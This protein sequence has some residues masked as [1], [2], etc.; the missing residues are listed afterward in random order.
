M[1]SI[2]LGQNRMTM[3]TAKRLDKVAEYYFSR[4]LREI[5][6]LVD[7]GADVINMGIGN[8]D[9]PPP[10]EVID[11]LSNSALNENN[12]GY[13]PYRGTSMFRKEIARWYENTYSVTLDPE[14]E[15]LPLLGSKEGIFYVSMAFLNPGDRV[16][17]PDPGYAPYAAAARLAGATP[18]NYD[19]SEEKGWLPDLDEL[20]K[21]DLGGVKL[22][23]INYPNMPTGATPPRELFEKLVSLA[24]D[25]GLLICHDNPY[26]LILNSESPLSIFQTKGAKECSLELNSL[27]KS[28]RMAGWRVGMICGNSRIIDAVTRVKSNVDSGMFYPVQAAATRAL[29]VNPEWYQ[30]QNMMY[31]ERRESAH[32]LLDTLGFT[33]NPQSAGLFVWAKAPADIVNV[34][35]FTN[36]LLHNAG[37]FLVPGSL[38]GKNGQRFIRLSLCCPKERI[39]EGIK[40]AGQIERVRV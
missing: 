23:W 18:V 3:P 37:I 35:L 36:Q 33:Y 5:A 1:E 29:Q 15:V 4:K 19:L 12:H 25:S 10:P 30:R 8:P 27:S 32:R 21:R 6:T 38:F 22:L 2:T 26:S 40:R 20:R 28:H 24:N 16:L 34:E 7:S 9:L 14:N 17:I 11:V 31:G 13:Q 39:A